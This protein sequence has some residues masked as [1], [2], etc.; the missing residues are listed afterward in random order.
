MI[1]LLQ[2]QPDEGQVLGVPEGT[3][4]IPPSNQDCLRIRGSEPMHCGCTKEVAG[5]SITDNT[6]ALESGKA[7]IDSQQ[8]CGL[9]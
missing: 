2:N 3:S 4:V 8:L 7:G 5:V 6:Q 9:E 1:Y